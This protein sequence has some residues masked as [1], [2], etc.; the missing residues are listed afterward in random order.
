GRVVA[1]WQSPAGPN[2]HGV[3][4]G[5]GRDVTEGGNRAGD[6]A[7]R[8]RRAPG[9]GWVTRTQTGLKG[10]GPVCG[11][12]LASRRDCRLIFQGVCVSSSGRRCP[13]CDHSPVIFFPA[14][15][16]LYS[17]WMAPTRAV[18]LPPASVASVTTMPATLCAG[19]SR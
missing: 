15:V 5:T 2:G 7:G 12:C 1:V 17:A 16:P 10:E 8:P 19:E 9:T 18:N 13:P 3:T 4:L 11:R 14:S 6:G